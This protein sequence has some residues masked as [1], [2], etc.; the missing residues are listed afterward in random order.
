[1]LNAH[2][3]HFAELEFGLS[4]TKACTK[5]SLSRKQFCTDEMT[6]Y[7]PL[8]LEER[9]LPRAILKD[10]PDQPGQ[11]K[12][13]KFPGGMQATPKPSPTLQFVLGNCFF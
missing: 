8:G 4:S 1:M 9:W 12:M 13:D 10:A 3:I 11:L 5:R 2:E 7:F 6:G